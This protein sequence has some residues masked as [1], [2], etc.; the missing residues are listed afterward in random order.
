VEFHS[1]ESGTAVELSVPDLSVAAVESAT[2]D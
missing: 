1:D 2:A